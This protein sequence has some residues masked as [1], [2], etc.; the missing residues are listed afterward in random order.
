MCVGWGDPYCSTLQQ[1]PSASRLSL[2]RI[3]F[4]RCGATQ[5]NQS[6]NQ[7]PRSIHP[8]I[9]QIHRSNYHV[10]RLLLLLLVVVVDPGRAKTKTEPL[11]PRVILIVSSI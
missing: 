1:A 7:P 6:I 11:C 4:F 10:S 5:I 3:H 9:H 2:T 8:S